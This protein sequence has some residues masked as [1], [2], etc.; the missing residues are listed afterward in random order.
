MVFILSAKLLPNQKNM[1]LEHAG[2]FKMEART[3]SN[4]PQ[5][6][7]M[8]PGSYNMR[9]NS[10]KMGLQSGSM[11]AQRGQASPTCYYK[12]SEKQI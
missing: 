2:T 9:L 4:D 8:M 12:C 5:V 11:A 6:T 7:K 1:A 10:A 3:A